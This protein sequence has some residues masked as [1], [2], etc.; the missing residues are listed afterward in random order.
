MKEVQPWLRERC[1]WEVAPGVGCRFHRIPKFIRH[2]SRTTGLCLLGLLRTQASLETDL[3]GPVVDCGEEF[4]KAPLSMRS[5][6]MP[7]HSRKLAR[8]GK[9]YQRL[10]GRLATSF[11]DGALRAPQVF[12]V[13]PFCVQAVRRAHDLLEHAAVQ[14]KLVMSCV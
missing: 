8:A 13:G 4:K 5:V 12:N 11:D 7:T 14:G 9:K 6:P 10:L 2:F 3:L 1:V